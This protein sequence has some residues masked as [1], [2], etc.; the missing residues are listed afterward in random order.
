MTGIL[1]RIEARARLCHPSWLSWP[2]G[3]LA[4]RTTP[5]FP[6]NLVYKNTHTIIKHHIMYPYIVKI[7]T[8]TYTYTYVY[9]YIHRYLLCKIHSKRTYFGLVGA[10]ELS[11][12]ATCLS[13]H[14][15]VYASSEFTVHSSIQGPQKVRQ[16]RAIPAA[17][18]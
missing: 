5:S 1:G 12:N 11:W 18:N 8:Y 4:K 17:S 15:A 7:Y 14:E 9:I 2:G 6:C 3:S 13:K 10:T 16:M